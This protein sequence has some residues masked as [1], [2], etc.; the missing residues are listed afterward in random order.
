MKNQYSDATTRRYLSW[1]KDRIVGGDHGPPRLSEIEGW[2]RNTEDYRFPLDALSSLCVGLREAGCAGQIQWIA[3]ELIAELQEER[4]FAS[5][6]EDFVSAVIRRTGVDD[7]EVRMYD[8]HSLSG[9][10]HDL[11]LAKRE[12]AGS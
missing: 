9:T 8:G 11:N 6:V 12:G 2:L 4:R 5:T 3:C 1:L 7:S 10:L